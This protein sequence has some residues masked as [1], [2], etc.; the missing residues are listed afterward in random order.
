MRV[1]AARDRR[2]R[3]RAPQFLTEQHVRDVM[4]NVDFAAFLDAQED[5]NATAEDG[6]LITQLRAAATQPL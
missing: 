1:A 6:R 4:G 3:D 5:D 2:N